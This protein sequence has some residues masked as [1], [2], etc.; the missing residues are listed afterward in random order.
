MTGLMTM[1]M[2]C[3]VVEDTK[4][5]EVIKVK[6]TEKITLYSPDTGKEI[7]S[8]IGRNSAEY[9]SGGFCRFIDDKTGKEVSILGG[10]IIVVEKR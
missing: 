6:P 5:E 9:G 7:S 10:G 2:G 4:A 1:N 8:W 3:K